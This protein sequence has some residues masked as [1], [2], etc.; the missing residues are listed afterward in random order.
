ME[1][2]RISAAPSVSRLPLY[3]R[4][5][6]NLRREGEK[7]ISGAAIAQ[8]LHLKSVQVRKDLAIA[9]IRGKPRAG[10]PAEVLIDGIER[11]LGWNIQRN[12]IIVG[13]GNLGSALI[14]Y[15]ELQS[16]G[17]NIVAGFDINPEKTGSTV[18]GTPILDM[19]TMAVNIPVLRVTVA[20]LTTP[21]VCAQDITDILIDAG[22]NAIWNFTKTHLKAP[23]HVVVQHEDFSSGYDMLCAKMRSKQSLMVC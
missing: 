17:L 21:G 22:I 16:S 10:Y 7:Y 3:L 9:G 13:V 5:I 2:I 20:I 18:H 14:G 23:S 1:N 15:K 4:A 11:F 8:E 12:A 6:R 19:T